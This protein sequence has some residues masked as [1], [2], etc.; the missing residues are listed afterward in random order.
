MRIINK[1]SFAFVCLLVIVSLQLFATTD[2]APIDSAKR[3]DI[4]QLLMVNGQKEETKNATIEMFR[5]IKEVAPQVPSSVWDDII[6]EMDIDALLE[7]L[8]PIYDKYLS[9][10]DI[11]ELLKFKQSPIGQ[12]IGDVQLKISQDSLKITAI[13]AQKIAMKVQ[14]KIWDKNIDLDLDDDFDNLEVN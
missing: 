12:K 2:K 14:Q 11:K 9:H 3:A 6:A 5:T 4:L 13:W 8:V 1:F 10:D 7:E